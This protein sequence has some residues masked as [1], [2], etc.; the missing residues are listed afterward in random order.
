LV[1]EEFAI[2]GADSV[3]G[4]GQGEAI[5]DVGYSGSVEYRFPLEAKRDDYQGALFAD[6]GSVRVLNPS[7]GQQVTFEAT[8][9]GVG[10][11]LQLPDHLVGRV[12]LGLPLNQVLP[13]DTRSPFL[14]TQLVHTF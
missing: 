1:G 10:L 6:R 11:R 5:G 7:I 2:G 4:F 8:G 3:R 14:Y 12:D 9:V 13:T